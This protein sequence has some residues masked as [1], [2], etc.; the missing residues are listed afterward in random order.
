MQR[1]IVD[2]IRYMKVALERGISGSLEEVSAYYFKSPAVQ[3]R[4]E[5]AKSKLSLF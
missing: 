1:V 3:M 5:T 4:E 2:V